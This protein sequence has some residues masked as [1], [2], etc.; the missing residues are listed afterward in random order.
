MFH[1][2]FAFFGKRFFLQ[3]SKLQPKTIKAITSS[4]MQRPQAMEDWHRNSRKKI[5]RYSHFP[6]RSAV[7]AQRCRSDGP[8]KT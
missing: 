1:D 4:N 5:R 8:N 3:R 7:I 6:K 2:Y